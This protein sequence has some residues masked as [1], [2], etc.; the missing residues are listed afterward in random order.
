MTPSQKFNQG[1]IVTFMAEDGIVRT[2][3]IVM[4]D[5]VSFRDKG[6]FVYH[7]RRK[8]HVF[9]EVV[10]EEQIVDPMMLD[11]LLKV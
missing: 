11:T 3:T 7:I 9:N 10:A 5:W 8:W 6:K 1:D 4:A 2:G